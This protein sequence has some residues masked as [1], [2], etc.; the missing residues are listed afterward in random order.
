MC[1]HCDEAKQMSIK[2]TSMAMAGNRW[3]VGGSA[4]FQGGEGDC[5]QAVEGGWISVVKG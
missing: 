2:V 1:T 3:D 5:E 4:D